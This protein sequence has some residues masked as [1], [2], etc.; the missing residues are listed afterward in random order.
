MAISNEHNL[1]APPPASRPFGIQVRLKPGD[2]FAKLVGPDWQTT[3]WFT[4]ESERDAALDD[5]AG[6]HL[7]SRRGDEPSV[8]FEKIELPA[9][10]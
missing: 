4:S 5:M 10:N 3:H 1:C 2:P 6:R 9:A 7:Y 8:L